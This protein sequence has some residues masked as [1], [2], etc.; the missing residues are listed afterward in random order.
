MFGRELRA[1]VDVVL[2]DPSHND[3]SANDPYVEDI[4][5]NQCQSYALARN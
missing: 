4:Q 5:E 2:G 1:P 3:Y